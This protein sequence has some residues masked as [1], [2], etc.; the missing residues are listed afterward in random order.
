MSIEHQQTAGELAVV[1]LRQVRLDRLRARIRRWLPAT[2]DVAEADALASR[3][4][5]WVLA[6]E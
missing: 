6:D 5:E 2:T 1:V 3:A 4:A